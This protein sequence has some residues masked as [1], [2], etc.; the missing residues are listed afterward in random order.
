[1]VIQIYKNLP[2]TQAIRGDLLPDN[3]SVMLIKVDKMSFKIHLG[4]TFFH[5]H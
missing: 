2:Y 3:V 5:F 1:M 4:V